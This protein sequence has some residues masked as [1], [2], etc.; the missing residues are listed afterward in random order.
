MCRRCASLFVEIAEA[1]A[2]LLGDAPALASLDAARVIL[3]V[4]ERRHAWLERISEQQRE[5]LC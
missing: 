3:H 4:A 1:R 2:S 5:Y